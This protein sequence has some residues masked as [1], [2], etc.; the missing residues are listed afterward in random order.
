[1]VAGIVITAA[2]YDAASTHGGLYIIAYGPIVFGSLRLL[3][4]LIA[5]NG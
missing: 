3:R 5:L 4:G 2:T 1:V